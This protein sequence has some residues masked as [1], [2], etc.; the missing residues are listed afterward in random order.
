M[1]DKKT[2]QKTRQKRRQQSTFGYLGNFCLSMFYNDSIC[3]SIYF[4]S[5]TS[6]KQKTKKKPST[7]KRPIGHIPH[8]SNNSHD[9]INFKESCSKYL[10]NE[11][12]YILYKTNFLKIFSSFSCVQYWVPFV[13]G[14]FHNYITH[15][16]YAVL[17]KIT[18]NYSYTNKPLYNF[19][20]IV[21]PQNCPGA[22]VLYLRINKCQN[23]YK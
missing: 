14:W 7:Y 20:P 4:F 16:I 8:L 17:K 2:P 21:W 19:E 15:W 9:Q 6:K 5:I 10:N 22:T 13:T 1:N 11:V 18:C 12:K 23:A 3:I